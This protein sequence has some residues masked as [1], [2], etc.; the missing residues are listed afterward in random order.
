MGLHGKSNPRSAR[1]SYPTRATAFTA[2]LQKTCC[3]PKKYRIVL[4]FWIL[5][6]N[7]V[8]NKLVSQ[9]DANLRTVCSGSSSRSQA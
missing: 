2:P 9:L 3:Q 4:M 6:P 1:E 5:V 7:L 8:I